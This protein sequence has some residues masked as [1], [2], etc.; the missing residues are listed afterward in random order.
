MTVNKPN[1]YET[2]K[3]ETWL[4]ST[5]AAE[6]LGVERRTLIRWEQNGH[7]KAQ[8]IGNGQRRFALSEIM[9]LRDAS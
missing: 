7:I 8:R 6:L 2:A 3:E 1:W 4:R 5:A 9:R